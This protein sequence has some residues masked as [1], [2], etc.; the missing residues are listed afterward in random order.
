[1]INE[2][3]NQISSNFLVYNITEQRINA[4]SS[5]SEDDRVRIIYTPSNGDKAR[6]D[7]ADDHH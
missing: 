4:D 5:G 1:M 7:V 2:G 3:G 6:P